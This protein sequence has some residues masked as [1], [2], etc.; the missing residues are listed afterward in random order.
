M[1][2]GIS[3]TRNPAYN[4]MDDAKA[5]R[6]KRKPSCDK[7]PPKK[8]MRGDCETNSSF[9]ITSKSDGS[10]V[11]GSKRK[12]DLAKE[13]PNKK[14]WGSKVSRDPNIIVMDSGN[15][16]KI[17]SSIHSPSHVKKLYDMPFPAKTSRAEFEARYI[18]IFIIG[19][20]GC[21]SVYAGYSRTEAVP[22]A[23]KHLPKERVCCT[24]KVSDY[25]SS[26]DVDKLS[27]EVALMVKAAGG[28][29]SSGRCAA[30]TLLDHF[31]LEDEVI[32]VM[33]R[34]VPCVDLH[35]YRRRKGGYLEEADAMV[36]FRQIVDAAFEMHSNGVFH[37]DIKVD[38]ILITTESDVPRVRV[39]YFGCG[40]LVSEEPYR[41]YSGTR[42]YAPPEYFLKGE[43]RAA[44][45]TVW[46]LGAL[47][48]ELLD[49]QEPF[50]TPTYYYGWNEVNW[51]L[52]LDCLDFLQLCLNVDP[53]KRA[54]LEQLQL[55]PWLRLSTHLHPRC[56]NV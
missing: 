23:I 12:A 49:H 52:S 24:Q 34:P 22:V 5:L 43:Y 7:E 36:I 45:T 53:E 6:N 3:D 10:R 19:K 30:I 13:N 20:G 15:E 14:I 29:E 4:T 37:R 41:R 2:E 46:Q 42:L 54:T 21:G 50:S 48:Y 40:C 55:H 25:I 16:R 38:N 8:K 1:V 11:R 56:L 17:K 18:E 44:P 26:H 28:V 31:D 47:L 35:T 32:L 51:S 9:L 27:A 39:I 33:E